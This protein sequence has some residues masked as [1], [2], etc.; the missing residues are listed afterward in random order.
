MPVLFRPIALELIDLNS[1][2][3]VFVNNKRV[4]Q[5]DLHHG[6]RIRIGGFTF[7]ADLANAVPQANPNVGLPTTVEGAQRRAS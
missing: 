5:V 4:T 2:N 3:G 6:D 1:L 7:Q